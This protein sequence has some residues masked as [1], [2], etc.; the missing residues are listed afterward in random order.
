MTAFHSKNN[1]V[2]FGCS[3]FDMAV[4]IANQPN[5]SEYKNL[6]TVSPLTQGEIF[7]IG[8]QCGNGWR[9]IFNIYAK[10]IFSLDRIS[11]NYC[12]TTTNW[13]DYRE[14]ALLQ[15]QS[16][17]ALLFS[18]PDLLKKTKTINI[19]CGKTYA[20]HLLNKNL[21]QAD[22]VWLDHEF[23]LDKD[24]NLI[25]CP[26]FDYRQLSNIKIE[27]LAKIILQLIA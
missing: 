21:I 18:P 26:Y 6:S 2:G 20:L 12:E 15:D 23:A 10:L 14:Q 5:M 24:K 19:L 8:Q 11:F 3:N 13:Q 1:P 4:F 22:L 9:K 25:V 7:N 27:R 17:T 16:K